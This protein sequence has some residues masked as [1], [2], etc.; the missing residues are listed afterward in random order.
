MARIQEPT[1]EQVNGYREWCESRPPAVRAVCERFEPWSLYRLKGTGDRCTICSFGEG[2]DGTVTLTVAITGEYNW[3]L[4]DREVFGINP[5]DL[6]PCELP[7]PDEITGTMLTAEQFEENI[8]AF[9][10]IVGVTRKH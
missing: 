3:T 8:E 10:A 4:F 9:R 7:G 5:D 6:E 2:K 1:D